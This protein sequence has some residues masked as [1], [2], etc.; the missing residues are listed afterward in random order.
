MWRVGSRLLVTSMAMLLATAWLSASPLSA[1][2]AGFVSLTTAGTAYTQDFNTLNTLGTANAIGS[3]P[4]LGG[5]ELTESGSAARDNEL[6]ATGT[7]S[8]GEGDTYSF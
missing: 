6:Y 4:G 3:T 1:R 2:A 8:S 7:G 5:W